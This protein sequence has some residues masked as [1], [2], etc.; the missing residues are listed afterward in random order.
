MSFVNE[1][2]KINKG[3]AF[4]TAPNQLGK[5]LLVDYLSRKKRSGIENIAMITLS[6]EEI[7]TAEYW[8]DKIVSPEKALEKIEPGMSIFVGTGAAEPRT[9]VKYLLFL[10]KPNLRDLEVI[11]LI[12]LG[13]AIP[14][15][16]AAFPGNTDSRPFSRVGRRARR[17]KEAGWIY[18]QPILQDTRVDRI[19]LPLK[20]MWPLYR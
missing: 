2:T 16:E 10:D 4:F 8:R 3:R 13:D 14:L 9:L 12:S 5:Y 18:P 17:S 1:V 15:E 6:Q 11:Q 20:S 19:R 7:G